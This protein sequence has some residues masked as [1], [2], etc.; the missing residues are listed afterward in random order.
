MQ[1]TLKNLEK[2][3]QELTNQLKCF[4]T[5]SEIDGEV[6][7]PVSEVQ[8]PA[9]A[10]RTTVL[11]LPSGLGIPPLESFAALGRKRKLQEK[12]A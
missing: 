11:G 2:E 6:S 8:L 9:P 4:S 7:P 3:R 12:E 1:P 10:Q 5:G